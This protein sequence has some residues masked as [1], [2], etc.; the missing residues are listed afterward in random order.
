MDDITICDN[1]PLRCDI[2]CNALLEMRKMYRAIRMGQRNS[3]IRQLR[4]KLDIIDFE[5][6][7]PLE[8]LGTQVISQMRE[9]RELK[10]FGIRIGYVLS[11]KAKQEKGSLVLADVRK[12]TEI[13]SA[14]LP[15]DVVITFYEP[16][17]DYMNDN[18]KKVVMWHELK[19]IQVTPKGISIRPHDFEDFNTIYSRFG[20]NWKDPGVKLPD[21]LLPGEK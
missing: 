12:V 10:E 17:I 14:Y 20:L 13:Y 19:H 6:S 1:C 5:V 21:I 7:K 4:N 8:E 11:N 18:Q 3:I 15:F 2:E 9:L 16:N